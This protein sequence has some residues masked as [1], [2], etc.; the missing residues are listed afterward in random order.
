MARGKKPPPEEPPEEP[1]ETAGPPPEPQVWDR[2]PGESNPAYGAFC[3]YRD[4]GP[5]RSIAKACRELKKSKSTV[6]PWS[7]KFE[8][9]ERT[10][11]WDD[12]C[13][14]Q[15]RERDQVE[16]QLGTAAMWES[17]S[18]AAKRLWKEALKYLVPDDEKELERLMKETPAGTLLRM[19]ELGME[20]E[21]RS[22]LRMTGRG[23][24][25]ADAKKLTE[26]LINI[27]LRYVPDES[28]GAFLSDIEAWA[29]I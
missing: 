24:D 17:H 11:A 25:P 22:R 9:V 28:H 26:D 10:K 21:A 18:Q 2:Q 4:L 6:A 5:Q 15:Q 29:T 13:D 7:A 1:Q 20:R 8:W 3:V 27:A 19:V 16:R 14:R 23:L 12:F